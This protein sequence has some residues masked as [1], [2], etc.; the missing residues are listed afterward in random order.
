M[1]RMLREWPPDIAAI[2]EA[3]SPHVARDLRMSELL[4][5]SNRGEQSSAEMEGADA[6]IRGF[7][8]QS[9]LRPIPSVVRACCAGAE[10]VRP[11][12]VR[13]LGCSGASMTCTGQCAV[14][15]DSGLA[16]RWPP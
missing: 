11:A 6:H 3:K 4:S 13:I 15:N 8:V 7:V 12:V 1:A 16:E 10:H 9:F 5:A 14:A 2:G